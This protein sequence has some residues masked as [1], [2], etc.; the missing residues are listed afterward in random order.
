MDRVGDAVLCYTRSGVVM[1]PMDA[2]Y[3]AWTQNF[4]GRVDAMTAWQPESGAV[5]GREVWIAGQF[6][7]WAQREL[8]ARTVAV[9]ENAIDVLMKAA[10]EKENNKNGFIARLRRN[11]AGRAIERLA[12]AAN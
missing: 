4:A 10:D 12:N 3:V 6:T 1:M 2:D 9:H 11:K 7:P 5:E 8:E